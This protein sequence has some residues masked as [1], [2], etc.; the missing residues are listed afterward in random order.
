MRFEEVIMPKDKY[1]Y[2]FWRKIEVIVF[3]I[4][5]IF[6]RAREE[7]FTNSLLYSAWDVFFRVFS[8][9]TE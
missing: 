8:A 9:T 3:I 1:L 2:K 7:N 5:Q 4:L 6:C